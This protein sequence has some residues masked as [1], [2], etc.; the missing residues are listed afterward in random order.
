MVA[1]PNHIFYLSKWST[2]ALFAFVEATTHLSSSF[3][4]AFV[5]SW[6]TPYFVNQ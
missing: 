6:S 1:F 3:Y 5:V 4:L 2:L